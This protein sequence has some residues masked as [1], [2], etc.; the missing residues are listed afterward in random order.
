LVRA[1]KIRLTQILINLLSNAAKFTDPGGSVRVTVEPADGAKLV[2][3]CVS[4]TGRGIP[5]DKLEK[6]FER[7]EQIERSGTRLGVGLGLAIC[8]QLVEA[9]GGRIWAQSELGAGS[10]FFFTLPASTKRAVN[11]SRTPQ[12]SETQ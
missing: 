6:V 3:F 8:R 2:K 10:R 1:D 4:D 7:F 9:Q 12:A 11:T 5:P